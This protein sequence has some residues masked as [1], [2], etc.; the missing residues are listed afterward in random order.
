MILGDV[1]AKHR[2]GI[3][4]P[5]PEMNEGMIVPDGG[6]DGTR[7]FDVIIVTSSEVIAAE[8]VRIVMV[9][10]RV[11]TTHQ[12]NGID[13]VSTFRQRGADVVILDVGAQEDGWLTTISRLR[14]IDPNV[15]IVM[16]SSAPPDHRMRAET[17]GLAHGAVDF[18]SIP[19]KTAPY[20]GRKAFEW[21][22]V[23]LVHA[24]GT[25]RRQM[26]STLPSRRLAKPGG[27]AALAAREKPTEEVVLRSYTDS[28]PDV[29]AIASSTG[30]PHAL[31]GFFCGLPRDLNKP[32]LVTQHM[33]K[34]FTA[35]LAQTITRKSG[36]PC[37][38]G[39][40]GMEVLPG[41]IYLAKGGMHMTVE[42]GTPNPRIRDDDGPPENFCKPAADPML[43]SV[44][45]IYGA[46]SLVLIFTGMGID[47]CAGGRQI[48]DIG[49]NVIVQDEETSVVWGMPGAAAKAGICAAVLPVDAMASETARLVRGGSQVRQRP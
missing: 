49:G 30:G 6:D 16:V 18:L 27:S 47:G 10:N 9:G 19:S 25:A 23:G 13:G 36:W 21:R 31:I 22:L 34:G 35:A 24:L 40:D 48:A 11:V 3:Q 15:I 37:H 1:L 46:R 29:I 20:V 5:A 26:G 32:I 8:I 14:K 45:Q 43:R 17:D 39:V 38:E 42:A 28:K 2:C 7:P 44:A 41:Y 4:E 12:K 33:P